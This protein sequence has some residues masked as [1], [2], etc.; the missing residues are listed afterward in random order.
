MRETSSPPSEMCFMTCGSFC[1]I[2]DA[3]EAKTGASLGASRRRSGVVT[4]ARAFSVEPRVSASS[5]ASDEDSSRKASICCWRSAIFCSACGDRVGAGDEAERRLLLLGDG[6]QR[7]GELGRVAGLLAVLAL[8]ELALGGVA[9]G[10]VLDGR[11]GVV[12]RLLGEQLGAEE[13]G[14]DDGRVDAE[15]LDLGGERLHPAVHAELRCGV[16]GA[17]LEAGE[18]RGRG[19]RHDVPRALLAHDGQ[20]RAR[21]VHRAD[22]A[23]RE[24]AL[25]LLGRQLLE[26][27]GVEAGGVVDQH[28]DAAEAVDGRLDRRLG[29]LRAGDV[30]LDDQQVVR[31]AERLRD[32]VGVAAGGDDVVAGGQR[33]LGDVDA[34]AASGAGDEPGL[35]ASHGSSA[36][37]AG[38]LVENGSLGVPVDRQVLA[39]SPRR[40]RAGSTLGAWTPSRRSAS[41]S[42]PAAPGS[43]PIRPGCRSYG[44]RR[45][46]GLRREEVAVLAGVS[47]PLLHAP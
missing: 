42:P 12:R 13:P 22:Q 29:V 30:E 28:V 40:A 26:V 5:S 3:V 1:R 11:R 23:R 21:D 2:E 36:K 46:P 34:H 41:S 19:D 10:V 38:S 27:A 35:L 8:P 14:V 20:D 37:P 43:R 7:L 44:T 18:P 24:L 32:G 15:R 39:G 33:G 16:G 45:V 4:G 6:Q 17:V 25:H 47:V 9:L 31:V